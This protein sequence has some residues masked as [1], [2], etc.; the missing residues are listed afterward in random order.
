MI[1][2]RIQAGHKKTASE[3]H[4]NGLQS[5]TSGLTLKVSLCWFG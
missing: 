5:R 4:E 2:V 3:N 1:A